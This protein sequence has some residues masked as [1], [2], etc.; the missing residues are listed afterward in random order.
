MQGFGA[1]LRSML[2]GAVE[3]L[4]GWG[5]RSAGEP[6]TC[7]TADNGHVA[8]RGQFNDL[9]NFMRGLR[10]D[11]DVGAALFYRGIVFVEEHVFR[12]VQ[13]SVWAENVFELANQNLRHKHRSIDGATFTIGAWACRRNGAGMATRNLC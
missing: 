2:A 3:G 6:G 7:A 9:G 10:K 1:F 8:P 5:K 11:N 4:K 12:E 13:N